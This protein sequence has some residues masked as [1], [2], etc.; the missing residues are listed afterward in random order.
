MLKFGTCQHDRERLFNDLNAPLE[1]AMWPGG[2]SGT[3][4]KPDRTIKAEEI[5]LSCRECMI[6]LYERSKN[7]KKS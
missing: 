4:V 1:F 6:W 7:E 5:V 3:L 2:L